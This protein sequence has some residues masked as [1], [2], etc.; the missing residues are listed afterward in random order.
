MAVSEKQYL[1]QESVF[2]MLQV[3]TINR[4]GNC[5]I[6]KELSSKTPEHIYILFFENTVL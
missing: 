1:L 2:V 3:F 4:T 5:F 6:M